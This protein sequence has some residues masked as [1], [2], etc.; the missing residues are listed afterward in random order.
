M[1]SLRALVVVAIV[2]VIFVG[3]HVTICIAINL[4]NSKNVNLGIC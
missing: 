1:A 4:K 2:G 3:F